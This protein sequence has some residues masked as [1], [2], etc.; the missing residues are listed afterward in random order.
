[1]SM[2]T[3]TG[4]LAVMCMAADGF[5]LHWR[6]VVRELADGVTFRGTCVVWYADERGV[7]W[8]EIMHAVSDF[9]SRSVAKSSK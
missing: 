6:P 9:K 4:V 1:M 3:C 7:L 5:S 8:R 2:S